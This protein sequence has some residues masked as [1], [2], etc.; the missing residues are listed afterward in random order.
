[1]GGAV[2]RE[3]E[4]RD[5]LTVFHAL[6]VQFPEPVGVEVSRVLE[7]AVAEQVLFRQPQIGTQGTVGA[8]AGQIHHP[9]GRISYRLKE[10]LGVKHA[11]GV[12]LQQS[13]LCLVG[14]D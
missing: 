14:C 9:P 12:R 11:V 6:D 5:R 3:L 13:P 10:C 8:E 1:M 2:P 7:N 4:E